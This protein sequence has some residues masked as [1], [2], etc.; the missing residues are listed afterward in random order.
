MKNVFIKVM[1]LSLMV[2]LISPFAIST[3]FAETGQPPIESPE[4]KH[5]SN[6][7]EQPLNAEREYIPPKPEV[8]AATKAKV[9]AFD[10]NTVTDVPVS[11]CEALV[12]LYESTNGAGW[13]NSENW[14]SSEPVAKWYGVLVNDA[15][16]R[17]IDLYDN[18]LVGLIPN[19]IGNLI[20]LNYLAFVSNQLTGSIPETIG[21]LQSLSVLYLSR[22]FL[23]GS[24]PPNF[25][26]LTNL[27]A[28]NLSNNELE[29][30]LP[31]SIGNLK[32]LRFADFSFNEFTGKLP[33]EIGSLTQ[34][35]IL[36]LENNRF[37]GEI[38]REIRNLTNLAYLYLNN[39]QF[40][41]NI[42]SEFTYM[43]LYEL[44]LQWNDF[45]G[46]IPEEL[47]YLDL[48]VLDISHNNLT[49][50]VPAS[51]EY[52][53][54]LRELNLS[55]NHLRGYL[56]I[57]ITTLVNLCTPESDSSFCDQTPAYGLDISANHFFVPQREPVQSFLDIKDPDWAD[58][59]NFFRIYLPMTIKS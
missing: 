26:A 47:G 10:C 33:V 57:E 37:S 45:S 18:N 38:P 9:E 2:N 52:S 4:V 44:Y 20:G 34:M 46:T 42:P 49:G 21:N 15:T 11:E 17:N 5:L 50:S 54:S 31:Q 6:Q 25:G 48:D 51:F 14:L 32:D 55:S 3:V 27:E 1:I 12:A 43:D 29:G 41:G 23:T 13:T 58:G 35:V 22:N 39:N 36:H 28:I 40:S 53:P 7:N 24:L 59:Q 56:P 16:V 8:I 19:E 30:P